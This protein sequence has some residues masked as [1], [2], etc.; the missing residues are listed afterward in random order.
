M[1]LRKSPHSGRTRVPRQPGV[2]ATLSLRMTADLF[3]RLDNVAKANGRPLSQEAE[4]R[5]EQSLRDEQRAPLFHNA[6]YG[7]QLAGWLELTGSAAK[8]SPFRSLMKGTATADGDWLANPFDFTAFSAVLLQIQVGIAPPEQIVTWQ[9]MIV[10]LEETNPEAVAW[11]RKLAR[12]YL[13][14]V[15][16]VETENKELAGFGRAVAAKLGEDAVRW[17]A[18]RLKHDDSKAR[19]PAEAKSRTRPQ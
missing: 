4:I 8:Y 6:V 9:R 7:S 5:L 14:A 10:L 3:E 2:R 16:G 12:A 13:A 18:A 11:G 19:P 15:A 17:I 1:A